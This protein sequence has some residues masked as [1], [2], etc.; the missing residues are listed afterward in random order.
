M[1]KQLTL[2]MFYLVTLQLGGYQLPF[3]VLGGCLFLS[4]FMTY[5]V[6]PDHADREVDSKA[7]SKI[8]TYL[9]YTTLGQLTN[10]YNPAL[11]TAS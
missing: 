5:L 7:G 3:V 9:P 4:A 2:K 6:L 8:C 11:S 1:V 10:I